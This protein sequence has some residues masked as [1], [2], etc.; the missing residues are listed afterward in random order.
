MRFL[1]CDPG[2][3]GG[4]AWVDA[5][6]IVCCQPTPQTDGDILDLLRSLRASGIESAVVEHVVGFI[7]GGGGGAMFTFGRG[8]GFLL[9]CLMALGFRVELVRP[10]KWQK[11]LSLGKKKDH[12]KDWKKHLKAEAQR[13]FPCCVVTLDTADALLILESTNYATS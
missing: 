4:F 13:R 7:P 3:H 2:K 11:A 6:G 9:G 12:G 5:N 1:A 8:F 10:A